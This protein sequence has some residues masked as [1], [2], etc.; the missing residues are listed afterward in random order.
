MIEKMKKY[1]FLTY[2]KDY[3]S[4]LQKLREAGVVHI[5]EKQ[6]GNIFEDSEL[7]N[8]MN[9]GKRLKDTIKSLN[10]VKNEYK[11]E[12]LEPADKNI[13]GIT[14]LEQIENIYSEREQTIHK[15]N[16]IKKEVEKVS[17]W[18]HFE[19]ENI[20][21]LE[22]SGQYIHFH[23]IPQSK[24]EEKWVD[25]YNA[26]KINTFNSNI[27]FIT[28]T[29]DP[30]FP[31]IDSEHIKGIERS[32]KSLDDEL[33]TL[34]DE[35]K[36]VNERL[37][38]TVKK[39]LN[40]LLYTEDKIT[41]NINWEKAI[42]NSES[43]AEDKI[44]VLEGYVPA[45]KETEVGNILEN[46]EVFYE[47]SE[48]QKDE[49]A[50]ILLK[51]NKFTRLFE[52]ISDLYDNPSYHGTDLTPFYAPFYIIFFG[53]CVGDCGY[54]LLY[55]IISFFLSKSNNNFLKSVSKLVLWLGVG[56]IIF[57]FISGTFFGIPLIDQTWQW[58]D[59]FKVVMMDSNQLFYFALILGAIQLTFAWIIKIVTTTIRHGFVYALDTLGWVVLL[60]GNII[61]FLLAQNSI[62][63]D[64]YQSALHWT[65][66]IAG[67]SMMLLFNSPEKGLK[68]IPLSIGSGLWGLYNKVTGLLGDILSYIRLFALGISGAVLGLVFNQLAFSFA[69]DVIILKQLVIVLI[70]L[71]GH[72]VNLF[73]CSLSA[74]VH[75]MRLT[76]VEFY[77]N[78]GFEGGGIKYNPFRKN[79]NNN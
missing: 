54:G 16:S 23:V 46:E 27:Y 43:Q 10:S 55:L 34:D 4:F 15:K 24:F 56:T 42:L 14:L 45:D 66:S 36:N 49:K 2:Y 57:G 64:S 53:L 73:L 1:T 77:N 67:F 35:L 69:P 30:G 40:T 7:Y 65:V 18:G 60:W 25:E 38:V 75:P 37:K 21:K 50:P 8:W 41:D 29:S 44:I 20:K 79:V 12:N 78:A 71:F 13:D 39:D 3:N 48:V 58:L 52:V 5:I 32:A 9:Y 47:V 74:F 31:D 11:I 76:F 63:P 19:P 72:A 17:P 6:R 33:N 70:L 68:G 62:I 22:R 61:V 28:I 51:N 59:K 26:I